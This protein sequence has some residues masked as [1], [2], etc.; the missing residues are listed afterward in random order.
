[1]SPTKRSNWKSVAWIALGIGAASLSVWS[2]QKVTKADPMKRLRTRALSGEDTG[3]TL[4]DFDWKAYDGEKLIAVA[5]VLEANVTKSRDTI[6]L[7]KVT[8]GSYFED[9]KPSFQ[10]ECD[11][12][13]FLNDSN[14]LA[15]RGRTTL[16]NDQM[17]L[18]STEFKYDPKLRSLIIP[19]PVTGKLQGGDLK[20]SNLSYNTENRSF[21]VGM[22][23]WEG[24]L[25]QDEGK[26]RWRFETL[27]PNQSTTI[28]GPKSVFG[29][30]RATDGEIIIL[31]DS[32][33]YNRDTDI[34]DAK[35][36]VQYFGSDANL[37]CDRAVVY[38][39]E[40]RA[41]LTGNVDMLI[42]PSGSEKPD[43]VIIPPVVP[44]VPEQI[45]K[46]RPKPPDPDKPQD[47]Q[48]K[49]VRN[50]ENI[51]DY[52]ISLTAKS[53]EYWYGKGNKHA[54]ING[55]PQ[56]RQELGLG[57]WRMVWA[58]SAFYDGEKDTLSLKSH[59]EN[60]SVRLLNSVG[61]DLHAKAVIVSTKKG[62]DMLDAVGL[63][64][65]FNIDE[66]EYPE[67]PKEDK[68][69]EKPPPIHGA[70]RKS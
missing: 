52:P 51:R 55:S 14:I 65:D 31:A 1:M 63:S 12:A 45:L 54:Q 15:G 35:G 4:K 53:I 3:V 7:A 21:R 19:Q 29:K 49:Q 58:D 25:A 9:N 6:T 18:V 16:S 66:S 38:R 23:K 61:D 36:H 69:G 27:D 13:T 33:E 41:L 48:E 47:T 39:K 26:K 46:T 42:K 2:I 32:A 62:E 10:F 17:Q 57:V 50:G 20:A 67:K 59:S 43:E 28:R 37:V 56:A 60:S 8:C 22:I 11:S 70:I 68:K 34:L 30:L 5:H 40:K 24:K 64:G 44:V